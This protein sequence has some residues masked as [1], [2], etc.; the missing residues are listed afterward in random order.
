LLLLAG[1]QGTGDVAA[2]SA[3]EPDSPA[4]DASEFDRSTKIL[5]KRCIIAFGED[6]WDGVIADAK[7]LQAAG[8]KWSQQPGLDVERKQA[9]ERL[10]VGARHVEEAAAK[11]D[12]AAV[13][14]A[15]G[16]VA[17]ALAKLHVPA[18]ASPSPAKKE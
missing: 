17:E 12:A 7:R 6:R 16:E 15:L 18:P 2:R 14:K 11:S 1:C 13:S 3:Y 5:F 10:Q 4:P 8:K 9:T